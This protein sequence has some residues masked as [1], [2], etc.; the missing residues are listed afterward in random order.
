MQSLICDVRYAF[1]EA[2]RRLGFTV[3]ALLTLA[4]GIGAVTTMYS[5][6][7]NILLNPFPYTDPRRMVDVVVQ[8]T[9][10]LHGGIRGALTVPEFRALSMRAQCSKKL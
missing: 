6:I 7:H 1:R 2:T 10:N 3:L 4:L 9:E 5:V 8:D